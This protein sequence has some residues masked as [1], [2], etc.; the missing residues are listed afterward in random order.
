M[1]LTSKQAI[2]AKPGRHSDGQG[3]YLLVQ[4]T[5]SKS[6][7]LRVQHKGRR[8]DFGLGRFVAEPVAIDIPIEKRKSLTLGQAREK[9]RLGRELAK[10]GMNPSVL[11]RLEEEKVPSFAQAA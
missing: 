2:N 5:G 8:R 9:A 10:A 4:P 3:L 7:V 11:W 6:W 1:S